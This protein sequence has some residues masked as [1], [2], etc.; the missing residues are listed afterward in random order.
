MVESM[1]AAFGPRDDAR[2][3]AA[4]LTATALKERKRVSHV[5][6]LFSAE[7][8]PKSRRAEEPKTHWPPS[9]KPYPARYLHRVCNDQVTRLLSAGVFSNMICD[10]LNRLSRRR[11]CYIFHLLDY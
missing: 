2:K 4:D 9:E 3:F 11:S 10:R 1:P 6:V 7:A 5:L 8:E